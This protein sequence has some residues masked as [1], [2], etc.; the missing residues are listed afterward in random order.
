MSNNYDKAYELVCHNS[1]T[2]QT[3]DDIL[4]AFNISH[5]DFRKWLRH[6]GK[7]QYRPTPGLAVEVMDSNLEPAMARAKFYLSLADVQAI[8][9]RNVGEKL[10][11]LNKHEVIAKVDQGYK[12]ADIAQMFSIS[13][14]RVCQIKQEFNRTPKGR[15]KHKKLRAPEKRELKRLVDSGEYSIAGAAEKF[16]IGTATAYRILKACKNI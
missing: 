15:K 2:T 14:A 16:G 9:Y 12:N 5:M 10:P 4:D 11:G 8:F 1:L 6:S 3:I 13:E 7:A